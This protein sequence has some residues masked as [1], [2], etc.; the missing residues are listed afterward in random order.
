LRE[1]GFVGA[2]SL[3]AASMVGFAHHRAAT[4]GIRRGALGR[5]TG[6]RKEQPPP[7][8]IKTVRLT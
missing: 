7:A 8:R 5:S 3:A 1:L 2:L 6:I 4:K